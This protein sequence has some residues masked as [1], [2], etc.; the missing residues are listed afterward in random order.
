MKP[1]LSIILPCYQKLSEFERVLP[2]NLAYFQNR[3]IE[4]I[5]VLDEN[6]EEQG[7]LALL[8]R[9]P[10][11]NW[12]MLVNDT[13]HD[14]R[15]PC[16]AIN[17]GLK[18][19]AGRYV[20]IASPESVFRGNVPAIALR[21]VSRHPDSIV[22]GHIAFARFSELESAAFLD[23]AVEVDAPEEQQ[24][25][26]YYG[27]I[28][29]PLCAFEAVQGYD[30]SLSRWGGDDDNIRIRLEMAGYTLMACQ[31]MQ[32]V[33]FSFEYRDGGE[34]Y[35]IERDIEVCSPDSPLA[36][37]ALTWG[38]DFDRVVT[39]NERKTT[40]LFSDAVSKFAAIRDQLTRSEVDAVAIKSRQR[41]DICGRLVHHEPPFVACN[42]CGAI[43]DAA[44]RDQGSY[45]KI[46]CVIQ[47]RNE[48]RYLEG[49]LAHLRG[50]VDGVV[51]L[52][53]GSTDETGAILSREP[54]WLDCIANAPETD[55]VWRE[56][57]NRQRLLERARDLGFEWVLC[58]DADERYETAF[59]QQLH[60]IAGSLHALECICISVTLKEL[61]NSPHQYRND[62]IWGRKSRA[63][64]FRLPK[65]IEFGLDQD[66]H[67][68]WYPDEIRQ[69]GRM[70]RLYYNLYHLRT[71]HHP[72][73]VKRR[74]RYKRLDPGN[75]F[76]AMGYDYLAEEGEDMRLELIARGREYDFHSVP[77]EP[78][79]IC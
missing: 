2:M 15:T 63:R 28:C 55:H 32:L 13:A 19:A 37:Q 39:I 53:D 12:K 23:Q 75:I 10:R 77:Q 30:E 72:D 35:E 38:R 58:C 62:G 9:F 66:L 67:G 24:L 46:A 27:S 4:V 71:I 7:F 52:D 44:R 73:R 11:V 76:Q 29:G 8:K 5:V 47:V 18:H 74:D 57:E 48:A 3:K 45:P 65:T 41:C 26:R 60:A 70:L 36:N 14:W 79:Q 1:I 33:H 31:Q 16:K 68:Q 56:R 20:L 64:F 61:W 17:V 43:P 69:C 54:G 6:R 40:N 59:L 22:I 51:A 49:C 42:S 25:H 34:Q 50:Y 21:A 78:G